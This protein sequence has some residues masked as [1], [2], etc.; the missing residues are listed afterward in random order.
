MQV[1]HVH[2][3]LPLKSVALGDNSTYIVSY[4]GGGVSWSAGL[5]DG[6]YDTLNDIT[7]K[8]DGIAYAAMGR[9]EGSDSYEQPTDG[10]DEVWFVREDN[11]TTW[12]GSSCDQTLRN[13]W[14]GGNED[15]R[16][17]TV[18]FAPSNGWFALKS[19]GGARWNNL[20]AS[21]DDALDQ[22]WDKYNGVDS[23]S[24][25]HNGEWFVR[26]GTGHS[27]WCGVHP[28]LDHM[29]EGKSELTGSSEWV[30]LGPNGTFVALFERYTL[31]CGDQ[32]L[33]EALLAAAE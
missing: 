18:H 11:G 32:D 30:E 24:V 6:L 19:G 26:Y 5:P 33:T 10:G 9:I 25:G 13:V 27:Q 21:L 22:Y 20:P 7:K 15:H 3:R 31:W 2:S 14:W 12:M 23:L 17:K 1:H 28:V 4:E 16:V 8:E 29:L